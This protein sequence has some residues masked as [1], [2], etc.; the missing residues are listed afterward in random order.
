MKTLP[1]ALTFSETDWVEVVADELERSHGG[2]VD[3]EKLAED[4][5][6][7]GAP[8]TYDVSNGPFNSDYHAWISEFHPFPTEAEIDR[9]CDAA[10][11]F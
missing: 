10:C 9:M 1:S 11:P 6:G 5:Y 7:D 2:T 3:R 4:I 8:C